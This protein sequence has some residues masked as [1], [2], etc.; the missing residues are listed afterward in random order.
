MLLYFQLFNGAYLT[1]KKANRHALRVKMQFTQIHSHILRHEDSYF[2]HLSLTNTQNTTNREHDSF[3]G[4]FLVR[5]SFSLSISIS[6]SHSSL[7]LFFFFC[8]PVSSVDFQSTLKN[9]PAT[10]ARNKSKRKSQMTED[11]CTERKLRFLTPLA[12]LA[13]RLLPASARNHLHGL[14]CF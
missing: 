11:R 1:A 13:R 5:V 10:R 3:I 7:C 14:T 6:S 4:L 8:L 2:I 9:W 12:C